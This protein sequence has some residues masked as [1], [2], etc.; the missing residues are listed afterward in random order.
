MLFFHVWI[1][2]HKLLVIKLFGNFKS[3]WIAFSL[4]TLYC[5]SLSPG[6]QIALFL[7]LVSQDAKNAVV[8]FLMLL[9]KKPSALK[10]KVMFLL[11]ITVSI[12]TCLVIIYYK[13]KSQA[14]ILSVLHFISAI[15]LSSGTF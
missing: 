9:G 11:E 1:S 3:I 4:K 5:K 2:F 8:I 6:T 12:N 15:F 13:I 14:K 10:T 7:T